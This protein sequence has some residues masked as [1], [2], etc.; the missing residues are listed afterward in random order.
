MKTEENGLLTRT[1]ADAAMGGLM[2]ELS[3]IHI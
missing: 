2:R 3:L 1:N